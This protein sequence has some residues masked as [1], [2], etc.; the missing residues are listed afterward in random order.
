MRR[1]SWSL[2]LGM[3]VALVFACGGK[4]D[5]IVDPLGN[6]PP[7]IIEVVVSPETVAPGGSADVR[8][9]AMDA[10]GD[11]MTATAR[12]LHGTVALSAPTVASSAGSMASKRLTWTGTYRNDGSTAAEQMTVTVTDGSSAASTPMIKPVTIGAGGGGT[13]TPK[14]NPTPTPDP[15]GAATPTPTPTPTPNRPPTVSVS[16]AS[17]SCHPRPATPCSVT[18]TATAS[19]VDGDTLTYL[20]SGCASGTAPTATCTVSALGTHTCSVSVSDGRGGT[21]NGSADVAGVNVAPT[22]VSTAT[23]PSQ[24]WPCNTNGIQVSIGFTDADDPQRGSGSVGQVA[25]AGTVCT[26]TS[27]GYNS[28]TQTLNLTI[29]T[30]PNVAGADCVIANPK[31]KDPWQATNTTPSGLRVTVQACP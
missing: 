23:V 14:P 18:C 13:T 25:P 17:A 7:V 1:F 16:G 28:D 11:D 31:W 20:W 29:S 12:A 2:G 26:L 24:P 30:G 3:A 21:G 10:D 4:G 5:N 19:D 22:W 15:G 8:I 27:T 6:T 9:V